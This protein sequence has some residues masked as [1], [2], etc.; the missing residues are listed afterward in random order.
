MK[1]L[2]ISIL[3]VLFILVTGASHG[4]EFL[5]PAMKDGL[6]GYMDKNENWI[7]RE[8][9]D[10]AFPF[11]QGLACVQY[12][13]RWGYINKKGQWIIQPKYDKA[14]PFS[15]GLACVKINGLWGF[16]D[17]AGSLVINPDYY[18]VSSFSEGFAVIFN[19]HSFEY[20]DK[21][22]TIAIDKQF[23]VAKPFT[24]GLASVIY[25]GE[26]G[27][28]DFNGNWIIKH[29][30]RKADAFSEGLALVR[31]G[32]K[33]G[34]INHRGDLVIPLM[35]SDANHFSD[36]LA[37]VKINNK[38]GYIDRQGIVIRSPEFEY[39]GEFMNELA[40]VRQKG[41]YG[42]INKNGDWIIN[43]VYQDLSKVS[44]T[45]S[46]EEE[47]RKLIEFRIRQ[48]ELK[49][50]FE[51]SEDYYERV[52]EENRKAEVRRQTF[53]AVNDIAGKYI[54]IQGTELGL[55]N[56]D[57]EIFTLFVPGAITTLVPVPIEDALWFKDNWKFVEILNPEFSIYDDKFVLTK[58]KASLFGSEYEY[59]AYKHG[60]YVS[61]YNGKPELGNLNITLPELEIP[62]LKE[63]PTPVTSSTV[64]SEVDEMI[65]VNNII[66]EN[67][68]ALIIGNE[69][70]SSYQFG[71]EG[72]INVKYA[73]HDARVFTEYLLKTFGV[74]SEN[75]TLLIDATA[76]QINQ[77]L[78]K[79]SALA[80]AY[81][82]KAEFIFYYAG[83]GL[84]NEE[85]REPFIIPVDVSPSDLNYAISLED[86]YTKYTAFETKRVSIFLDACFSGGARNE[87]LLASRGIRIRPK[88]PFV[89]GNLIVFSATRGD[90]T[91]YAYDEQ[92]HGMFTF[93]LLKKIQETSGMLSY[94]ELAKYLEF[95]VNKRS[96]LVNNREQEPTIKV[97]PILEYTWRDF[98]F[99]NS[100]KILYTDLTGEY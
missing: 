99:L 31:R 40:V 54:D 53:I 91:A 60:V 33:Y 20:I 88:S 8:R 4:Q 37:S 7:I 12:Y 89:M 42:I 52:T 10:E 85:T 93:H 45:V 43:P 35:Y 28:I 57:A 69:N 51:K 73:E 82:G 81:E 16:I 75:I 50:E 96:L 23:E 44:S 95:E 80:K 11:S 19:G 49:G 34:F 87:S 41:K 70:Y 55:Y 98:P 79:M 9:F 63:F 67:V 56:A 39:A 3:Y 36:G 68:F 61:T 58:F 15:E 77:A 17:K 26:K 47:L 94:G 48:W 1:K 24:D 64:L 76:G 74:P 29:E 25:K 27:Y 90:Q 86:I 62:V 65:P 32:E 22:G 100:S 78:S 18:A 83:H 2:L 92:K 21:N 71:N 66:Q 72:G 14:K 13:D 6:W 30:F 97:S 46:L 84:P 38:W 59:D 5:I